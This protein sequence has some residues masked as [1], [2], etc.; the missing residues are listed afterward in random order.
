MIMNRERLL[1]SNELKVLPA[2]KSC[3]KRQNAFFSES[4][5]IVVL[6]SMM[7]QVI[8]LKQLVYAASQL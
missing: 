3:L 1:R 2:V 7:H 4:N 5:I 6:L 8:I